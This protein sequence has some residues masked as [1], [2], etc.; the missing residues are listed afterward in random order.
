MSTIS[1]NIN[2][3]GVQV[4][5]SSPAN[6]WPI[7]IGIHEMPKVNTMPIA[8]YCGDSKPPSANDFLNPLVEE[9]KNILTDGITINEQVVKLSVRAFICD[10]PARVFIKGK[11]RIKVKRKVINHH[12]KT[13]RCCPPD[14]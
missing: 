3:D 11:K 13:V 5:K 7:L 4:F 12:Q 10:S 9:L 6:F 1:L 14:A 2:I 8:I